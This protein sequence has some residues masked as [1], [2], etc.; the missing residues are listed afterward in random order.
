M[1][2]AQATL[3]RVN[4]LVSGDQVNPDEALQELKTLDATLRNEVQI[5]TEIKVHPVIFFYLIT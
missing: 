5:I 3:D 2:R 4:E 1:S